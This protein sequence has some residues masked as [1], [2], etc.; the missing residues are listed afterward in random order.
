MHLNTEEILKS[1]R[2]KIN[3]GKSRFLSIKT[4]DSMNRLFK[5]ITSMEL[6]TLLSGQNAKKTKYQGKNWYFTL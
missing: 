4:N 5:H 3:S 2:S 6:N 1:Y